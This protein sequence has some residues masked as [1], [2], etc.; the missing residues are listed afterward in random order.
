MNSCKENNQDLIG[1]IAGTGEIPLY[2]ARMAE[3]KGIK[4]VAIAFSN[5]IEKT[6]RPYTKK[7]Y[8]IGFWK[9]ET[10]LQTLQQENVT[11]LL[12]LGKIDKRI[13]FKPQFPEMRSLRFL[14]RMLNHD[15]KTLLEGVLSE[16]EKEGISVLSQRDYLP[17]LFPCQG[18]LT[19]RQPTEDEMADVK[20]GFSLARKMADLEVGQ[21]VA[22]KNKT[23]VAIEALEG[24]DRALERGCE[25]S[26]GK[27][28]A[29]KVSRT[30]QDFRFDCPG[31]GVK[32]IETLAKGDASVLAIE[33][34]RVMIIGLNEVIKKADE[35]NIT[36][37][38][39]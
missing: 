27:C 8:S 32:T 31:V 26:G 6:L 13:V 7:S 10:I 1:L 38:A 15:D 36:L 18:V 14:K 12:M 19:Q 16:L 33:A 34:G 5:A 3:K 30:N 37:V 24:T 4:I 9:S 11:S 22:V 25:L 2:F 28:V 39:I 17:E 20:Y 35:E 23:A 29:V 21:T